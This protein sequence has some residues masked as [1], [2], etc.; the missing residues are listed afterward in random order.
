[1][2]EPFDVA[3]R[4]RMLYEAGGNAAKAV[5]DIERVRAAGTKLGG[6]GADGRLGQ[7]LKDVSTQAQNA[8]RDVADL[9]GAAGRL[10]TGGGPSRLEADLKRLHAPAGAV[11]RE[12]VAM[13]TATARFGAISTFGA[14]QRDVAR[15]ST[16]VQAA[17][18]HTLALD[19]AADRLGSGRGVITLERD[20]ERVG[21]RAD[22]TGR[23]LAAMAT[24]QA[25]LPMLGHRAQ[26]FE[27]G[28]EAL[29]ASGI[30]GMARLGMSGAAA[31][32]LAAGAGIASV[33]AGIANATR[34]AI[35]FESAM[36]EV[37]KAVNDLTPDKLAEMERT[38]LRA[39]RTTG[40]AKEEMA[41]LVAQAGFAGRPTEELPRFAEFGAKAAGA[42][43]MSPE[44]TGDKLA[45]L[46]NV[47][48]LTQSGIED[49]ADGINV[50]GDNTASKERQIV[51]FLYR[52]GET[53]KALKFTALQTA[54]F[55]A[56]AISVGKEAEVA[57]TGFN[58][59]AM[60]LGAADRQGED[61]KKG[62]RAIGLSARQVKAEI[63][64]NP[65]EGF[66]NVLE[67]INK[68]PENKKLDVATRLGG[69][70]YGD[71]LLSY[72]GAVDEVRKSLKL[73]QDQSTRSGSVEKT[74]KI[75]DATTSRNIARAGAQI[76][77]FAAIMGR[78]FTPIV[79]AAAGAV[80][81]WFGGMNK[82]L[83]L[84]DRAEALAGRLAAGGKLS[85]KEQAEVD[86]NPR[87]KS[88]V[89]QKQFFR[90]RANEIEGSR[91]REL[92]PEGVPLAP[93][94]SMQEAQ[95]AW[96]KKA[97]DFERRRNGTDKPEIPGTGKRS[98]L[99]D[100]ARVNLAA[101]HDEVEHGLDRTERL[102]REAGKRMRSDLIIKADFG[103][104]IGGGDGGARIQT[105]AFGGA[106]RYGSTSGS[107]G[108]RFGGVG[109][110]GSSGG[111]SGGGSLRLSPGGRF[112]I[113]IPDPRGGSGAGR[114]LPPQSGGG[115]D[116]PRGSG[117][118]TR[119]SARTGQMMSYAMDQLRREGVP[120]DKLR[121]AAA[122][123]VGQAHMESGLDP[124]KVH[125]GGTGF[126][127]YGARDPKP[128][129]GR[130]TEMFKWLEKN[131]YARNSAEGQMRYM[132]HEAMTGRFPQTQRIL[133]GQ[134]SGDLERDT[135]TITGEFES[136]K[137][138]NRRSGAVREALRA[139][140]E[141]EPAQGAGGGEKH[142]P[143][144]GAARRYTSGFGTRTHPVL[145]GRR[146]HWGQDMA[147]PAGTGVNAM[148][149]GQVT[150][151][152]RHGD[153]TITHPDGSTKTYRHIDPEGI[154]KGQKVEG[155]A[156]IGRLR[157]HDPRSTGPHLHME[158]TDAQGKRINPMGDIEAAN[159]KQN[160]PV[161]ADT[162]RMDA[163]KRKLEAP[164][165]AETRSP[166]FSDPA[167]LQVNA[168]GAAERAGGGLGRTRTAE[169]AQRPAVQNFYG[170]FDEQGV[171]RRAQLEQNREV[172]RT[173][174]RALHDTGRLV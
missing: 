30:G 119:G 62:L 51:D 81:R 15:V 128:G 172:R 159:R 85:A 155:G 69:M 48:K 158:A 105:A 74:F 165:E 149:G 101:Y 147:A 144:G 52:T 93:A 124:N 157:A 131:G 75:F 7:S 41:K 115:A 168:R 106:S 28:N 1:M 151:V 90:K 89:D 26:R 20:I 145:G 162:Q 80:E 102:V 47:F 34:Q 169:A 133:K 73:M 83:E 24:H 18:T 92:A 2:T 160:A 140:P 43:G 91:A 44:D 108:N 104:A 9:T 38:I 5:D 117:V 100:E 146:M 40:I 163:S 17:S 98:D 103:A 42:F 112:G 97:E 170:G 166:R 94:P 143:L 114:G 31:G 78:K 6:I 16:S 171:A 57:A 126:G 152:S 67:R 127:I 27:F 96:K 21:R 53:G 36:A 154:K 66:L 33:G 68:L 88:A 4:V 134:G 64:A 132:A 86:A 70:E 107:A 10:G 65:V 71:D 29:M 153:V 84:G 142:D 120:Q 11:T 87:L 113:A 110:G 55:G 118:G 61:F 35:T 12:L 37:Q 139:G 123:L 135:N 13:G 164:P 125:D 46:G 45:K 60:K 72:A 19:R 59:F 121:D 56:A 161:A 50:L 141:G 138:I 63:A 32:G 150:S 39:S 8:K 148:E 156:Q 174:A 111:G 23:K 109:E 99:A 77:A 54:A 130:R 49:V 58:A 22:E 137:V 76:D 25:R 116:T 173:Q 122:H 3:L 14:V 95:E 167:M 79:N 129:Q 136:P 82:A